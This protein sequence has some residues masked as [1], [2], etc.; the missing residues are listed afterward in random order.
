MLTRFGSV[1]YLVRDYDAAIEWF[2]KRLGFALVEDTVLAP[3]TATNPAKRWVVVSPS[4]STENATNMVLAL[5]SNPLQQAAV[6]AQAGG[7][8][9][10]FLHTDNIDQ[11]V[12]R[13]QRCGIKFRESARRMAYGRVAVF[14][15]LYGQPWDLIQPK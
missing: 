10:F 6:G 9:C 14:E 5:A 15:D 11:D 1:T 3:A 7:R 12:E 2:T 4:A 13:M 8:V